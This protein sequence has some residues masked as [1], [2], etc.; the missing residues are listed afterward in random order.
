[1][2][3]PTTLVAPTPVRAADARLPRACRLVLRMLAGIQGGSIAVLDPAGNR[4]LV[5]HGALQATLEVADWQVFERILSHGSIGFGEDYMAGL[6]RSDQL[7][8]LL[9]LLA[10]N[11]EA[12]HQ[13]IHGNF[14]RLLAHRLWHVLHPNT[15]RGARRNIAAHYDLGNDF[16][17]LWLDET[18]SY[19]SACYS[20]P[21]ATLAEA[22]REKYRRVLRQIAPA[23]GQHVLEIGCGWGGFAEVAVQEFA[24]RVTGLTLSQEQLAWS[25]ERAARGGFADRAEFLLCDYRDVQGQYDHIVSIEMIEAVGEAWWPSYFSRLRELLKPGGRAVLQAITID[26][27]LFAHYRR[28]VDFIQR[29]IFLGGMLPSPA[30]VA[31]QAQQAGLAIRA[32]AAFGLDY[33]R[34][35]AEWMVRFNAQAEAVRAQGFDERF[36]RMWQFY[37]AYCEAGFRAGSTDVYHFT[38]SHAERP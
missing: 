32:R 29:Y 22:Q 9:S 21:D 2:T 38:L 16:Y 20:A 36:I 17:A 1:M 10:S 18:M 19:S 5:G 27:S 8:A 28:D 6:W 37:L 4:H 12:L 33:A 3:T 35:L 25:R 34:T 7:Q 31:E 11:R 15:R 13:A 24:C 26:E 14:L 23:P 30:V